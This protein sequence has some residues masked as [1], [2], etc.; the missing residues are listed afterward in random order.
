MGKEMGD[1]EDLSYP[2][3]SCK[4]LLAFNPSFSFILLSPE[5]NRDKTRKGIKHWV[6]M[7]IINLV[8][9]SILGGFSFRKNQG[10]KYRKICCRHHHYKDG[11][12]I[13]ENW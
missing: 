4:F 8:A 3:S 1:M 11:I 12:K 6:K 10:G 7:F 9:N 5:G 2:E 13:P